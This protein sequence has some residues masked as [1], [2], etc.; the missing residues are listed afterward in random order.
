MDA[1]SRKVHFVCHLSNVIVNQ[2]LGVALIS[3]CYHFYFIIHISAR[4]PARKL[5]VC[6]VSFSVDKLTNDRSPKMCHIDSV[7]TNGDESE[8]LS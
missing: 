2:V 7:M 1:F 4:V 3:K 6:Q 5:I 8:R